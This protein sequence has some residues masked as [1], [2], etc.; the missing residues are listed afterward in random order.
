MK[1]FLAL[2]TLVL[3]AAMP[4]QASAQYYGDRDGY[5]GDRRTQ[6]L[7]CKSEDYR[8]KH[9]SVSV[10]G[11]VRLVQQISRAPCVRGRSWGTDRGGIWVDGGCDAQFEVIGRGRGP[12][13]GYDRGGRSTV[14]HCKS[15]DFRHRECSMPVRARHVEIRRQISR[16]D[17]HEGRNWGWRYDRLWVDRGCE[18]DFVVYY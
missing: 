5:R 6:S 15:D 10:D 18:A 11:E 17:C 16:T 2:I 12:D 1:T 13:R 7:R 3:T 8:Y 9:C 4:L 14:V